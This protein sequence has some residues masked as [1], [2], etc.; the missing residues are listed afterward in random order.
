[1][2]ENMTSI[3]NNGVTLRTT[4]TARGGSS[5]PLRRSLSRQSSSGSLTSVNMK[6]GTTSPT[7]LD[8]VVRWRSKYDDAERRRKESI[9]EHE[10]SILAHY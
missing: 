9:V 5:I 10:K 4:A 7:V 3:N 2:I 6:S 1:M 8:E